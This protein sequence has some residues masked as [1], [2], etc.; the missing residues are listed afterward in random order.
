MNNIFD[1]KRFGNYLLYDLRR[2]KNNYGF[3]MLVLGLLPFIIYIIA[4]FF[5]LITGNGV[6]TISDPVKFMSIGIASLVAMLSFSAKVYGYVT[7][8]RA[9]SDFLMLPA[10]TLEKWIS[11]LLLTCVA[12]P[13]VLYCLLFLCDGALGLFFP[14][15]YGNSIFEMDFIKGVMEGLTEL[16]AQ[17]VYINF[18]ALFA[19][20]WII[21]ILTFT[22]G[23][24]CFKKAKIAKTLLCIFVLS[25]IFSAIFA[26]FLGNGSLD[27]D[28][29]LSHFNTPD[30][31]IRAI[32]TTLNIT[33]IFQLVI[34]LGGTYY[35]LRTI[36]H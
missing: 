30:H 36:K 12:A 25:M 16:R 32:N 35:R 7:E 22:L 19:L 14:N 34:L 18:F 4:Q 11:M 13:V 28:W 33:F 15:S 21:N 26:I 20:D 27:V 10:S 29:V 6:A 23:A 2:A 31:A 3:S 9:G 8:K 5:S 1:I 24:I 17:G